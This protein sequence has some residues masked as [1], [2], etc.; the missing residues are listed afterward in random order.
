MD[1]H[2]KP[3]KLM[4][5]VRATLRVKHYSPRTEKSYCFRIHFNDTDIV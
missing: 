3:A 4:D 5:R 1:T 2:S